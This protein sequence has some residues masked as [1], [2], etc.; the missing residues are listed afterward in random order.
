T[1]TLAQLGITAAEADSQDI[2]LL[3]GGRVRLGNESPVDNAQVQLTFRDAG[4][5]AIATATANA[6][7]D[8]S[9]WELIGQRSAI[10][11]GT[12]SV[13]YVFRTNRVTGGNADGYFDQAFLYKLSENAAPD[14]GAYGD[15]VKDLPVAN[16]AA[17]IELRSPDFYLD[18][19]K[20]KP[21]NI[22]WETFGN[23]DDSPV[24]IDVYRD[25]AD[26]PKWVATVV[27]ATPDSGQYTWI[28]G[29]SGIDF[30]TQGLRIQVSLVNNA[31]V[32]DRSQ[33]PFTVPE[34]GATYYVNDGSTA[35]DEYTTAVGNNR[36]TG[37]TPDAPK[38]YIANLFRAYDLQAGATLYVDTGNYPQF[39]SLT[40][41]GTASRGYGID[42]GFVMTGPT[43]EGHVAS[44][45]PIVP[46]ERTWALLDMSDTD[47]VSIS[48]LQLRDAQRGLLTYGGTEAL[49]LDDIEAYGMVY[50]G[51]NA[52]TT[53][54]LATWTGLYMHDN[55]GTGLVGY[56]TLGGI[57]Q[58]VSSN[59]RTDG[60]Y[61]ESGSLGFITGSTF[62]ANSRFG[63]YLYYSGAT[64][65]QSSTF[66]GNG[67]TGLNMPVS[68]STQALVGSTDLSL[69]LGNR[70]IGNANGGA[71]F[72]GN[73][74]V[75][76]NVAS[77]NT[78][79]GSYGISISSG[80]ARLNVIFGNVNGLYAYNSTSAENRV[81]NNAG[82]GIYA[83]Y[84]T[85]TGN[86]IY[87]NDVG[88]YAYGNAV[89]R[90]NLIYANRSVGAQ[91]QGSSPQFI[92]NTV[93][94]TAG[95]AIQL[96]GSASS[97]RFI[98]N[99]IWV[100]AGG[101][102]GLNVASDSQV[103]FVSD[104]NIFQGAV[105]IW[106]GTQRG[107]LTAWQQASFGDANSQFTDPLFVNLLG[108]DGTLGTTDDDFHLKSTHGSFHGASLAPVIGANGLPML[109]NGTL[110]N[111]AQDSPGIDRG[112]LDQPF[113]QEPAPRG[114]YV[115]IG[116][117][118]NTR[119]AS[120]SPAVYVR[121]M[122]PNGGET[123]AEGETTTVTWRSDGFTGKV[124]IDISLDGTNWLSVAANVDNTGSYAWTPTAGQFAGGNYLL[125]VSSVAQPAVF[126]VSDAKFRLAAT[127]SIFYVNDGSLVGDEYATAI[128]DDAN[129][130]RSADKPKAS[131]QALLNAYDFKPGDIILIDAGVYNLS[132]NLLV[133]AQDSGVL[134][135]GALTHASVLNRGNTN[136]GQ[137]ALQLGSNA[138]DVTLD[139]LVLSGGQYG[140]VVGDNS[141]AHRF[142]I[143]NSEVTGNSAGG[144]YVGQNVQD[145]TITGNLVHD[146]GGNGIYGQ[147][148]LRLEISGNQVYNQGT[149]ISTYSIGSNPVAG[150]EPMITGNRVHDVSVGI[151]AQYNG[152]ILNNTVWGASDRGIGAYSITLATGNT[153]WGSSTGIDGSSTTLRNNIVYANSTGLTTYNLL[154][155]GNR[156][157][158]NT[159]G[160]SINGYTLFRNNI[161]YDN[162]N[163]VVMQSGYNADETHGFINNTIVQTG[164]TAI[165][166]QNAS[167]AHL[168][169]NIID[170]RGGATGVIV[171][172]NSEGGFQSDYNL[173]G[174][175]AGTVLF[176]WEGRDFT[177]RPDWVYETGFDVNSRIA[178]ASFV[179]ANGADDLSG[180][181]SQAIGAAKILDDGDA[182][183]V[184]TGSWTTVT[185]GTGGYQGDRREASG[186]VTGTGA[187]YA[188]YTFTGLTAGTYVIAASWNETNGSAGNTLFSVYDGSAT[189]D[190]LTRNFRVQQYS[191]PNDYT[192]NGAKWRDLVTVVVTGDTLTLRI[193]DAGSYGKIIADAVKIQRIVG[194]AGAD[195][196]FHLQPGSAGVDGGDPAQSYV[197][198]PVNNGA[199]VDQGAY[200]NTPG[201]TQS[202]APMVQVIGPA[203]FAKLEVGTPATISWHTAGLIP[204]EPTLL[205]NAGNGGPVAGGAQGNWLRNG[206]MT[207]SYGNSS[208]T[209][210]VDVSGVTNPAPQA[211]YQSFSY[212][213]GTVGQGLSWQLPVDDGTYTVRLHFA[214]DYIYTQPGY[215]QFDIKLNGTVVQSNFDIRATTGASHKAVVK[216]Y[217]VTASGGQGIDLDLITKTSGWGAEISGI[218]ILRQVPAG[219]AAATVDLQTSLDNGL[220]WTTLASGLA[221]DRF[222]NGSY[223]WTPEQAT[224]ANTA[225]IRVIAHAGDGHVVASD[226]SDEP[227][228]IA[229]GG[230]AYYVNDG[231][232]AGD[233]YTTAIGDNANS[234]KDA[235][236]PMASLTALL[237]AY[238]LNPGDTVYVDTGHYTLITNVVIGA[239][240]SGV[241]VVGATVGAS[242]L[243]RNNTNGGQYPLQ[244]SGATGVTIQNLKLTGGQYGLV[245]GD[246]SGSHGFQLIG[247]EVYG[248]TSGGIYIGQNVAD[249]RVTGNLVHDNGGTGIYNQYTLRLVISGNEVYNQGAGIST[250][251]IGSSAV[252]GDETM[253]RGN[254]VHDV[255]VG[256]QVQYNGSA[257]D[258]LIWA[259]SDRGLA[260]YS[261]SGTFTGN[262]IWGSN[263]G[264]DVSSATLGANTV[265]GST[266]GVSV[267]NATAFGLRLYDN[268]LGASVTGYSMFRNNLLWDNT[269]AIRVSGTYSGDDTQGIVNNTIRQT[270]GRA[271]DVQANAANVRI[272]DNIFAT[273]DAQNIVVP[274]NSQNGYY[275]DYNLFAGNQ[276]SATAPIF[277]NWQGHDF[278]TL[279][280][281]RFET[282]NDV[283]SQIG[284]ANFAD[285]DGADDLSGWS[286]APIGAARI[287]DD[288]DIGVAFTGSWTTV[289]TG[290][291]GFQNDRR[292]ASG[293][294]TGS[295][296][297]YATYTFTGL[298][299]GTYVIAASWND[300]NGA[301]SNTL[302]SVYDGLATTGNLTRNFR[303]GQNTL[304]SDYTANGAKWRDL[305]TVVVTGDT[306]TVRISD[307]GSYGKIIADA[308]KI[309]Q[310][311]GDAGADDDFH[312]AAGSPGVDGGDPTLT[313]VMEPV[314]NGA[315]I[316][317][318]AYGNTPEA[319][320]SPA[321]LIQ[322]NG[323][324]SYA[325][326][327]V[328]TPTT[329]SWHTA[330]LIGTEPALLINAGNTG[331][332]AG[333]TLGNWVRNA[334]QTQGYSY[335]S[336]TDPVD[337]SGVTN[338]APQS[339][340]QS[341]VYANGTVGQG[342][343]W[344]LPVDD[345]Q[346]VV[347]LH[348][349]D[350]Y[351]YTQPGYRKIDIVLN[352]TVVQ[353]NFDIRAEAGAYRKAVVKEFNVVAS[354]GNGIDL[355]LIT[356]NSGWGAEISGIEILRV[357]PGGDPQASV[358]LQ[359]SLDNGATWQTLAT[360]LKM[361][362][363]GNGSY[364][365][366]PDQATGGNTALIRA[367]AHAG[368]GTTVAS[369]TSDEPFLIANGGSVF[370]VNDGS[371]TGDE[372]TTAPGNNANSGKDAAHPM[373]S[374]TALLRAYDLNPGDIVYV[375]TGSY[376]QYTNLVLL[377][378]DSGV[379]IQGPTGL[380]HTATLDRAN[381]S[382]SG[383]YTVQFAGADN[384]TLKNLAITGGQYGV[385]FGTNADSDGNVLANDEIHAATQ[386]G[387]W[388]G[389]LNDNNTFSNNILRNN[390]NRGYYQEYGNNNLLDGNDIR[391]NRVG[392]EVDYTN[393]TS[394]TANTVSNNKIH[395]NSQYGGYFYA[396]SGVVVKGNEVYNQAGTGFYA[397]YS[398]PYFEANIVHHN[399]TGFDVSQG[400]WLK[401][402]SV[403][404]NT[405]GINAYQVLIEGNK[406]YSNSVGLAENG[407]SRVI[408]NVIYANS[409]IGVKVTGGHTVGDG[410]GFFN[411]TILQL[412]GEG[413]RLTGGASD[414]VFI[415]NI[416]DVQAGYGMSVDAGSATRFVSNNNLLYRGPAANAFI[417]IWQG[418]TQATLAGW[419]TAS[420]QDAKSVTGDPKFID[421]DGAD[422][423]LG[424]Q[425]LSTGNGSDDNFELSA[426]SPAIDAANAY[427]APPK[428]LEGRDRRDDPASTN[429]GQGW[430]L[431]VPADQGSSL[432]TSGGTAL[433]FRTSDY[434][435]QITLPFAFS[436]YGQTYTQLW[437]NVNGFIQFAGPDSPYTGNNNS[438]DV[439]L[440]NVRI[441]VLWDDLDTGPAGK[442]IFTSST[443]TSYTIRWQAKLQGTN[444]DVNASLTLF[445]NGQVRFDYG[446][447]NT[448]L[449]PTVG[450]SAGNGV[451]YVLSSY[452]GQ[453]S[454]ASAN[455]LLWTPTPGLVY[456]DIG[457]YEFQGNSGDT[458]GP[459]VTTITQ[460]P[461]NGGS[462]AAAFSSI[463]VNFDEALNGVSARSPANYELRGAGA[464][465]IFDTGDD[466]LIK[467]T[468]F[469]SFP[470]TSLTLNFNG[471]LADGKYRLT[472]SGTKAIFDTAGNPLDGDGNGTP[473]GDYIRTFTIDRSANHAPVANPMTVSVNENGSLT[474]TLAATDADGDVLT[475]TIPTDV[476]HGTL[477]ALDPNTHQLTYTPDAGFNGTDSFVFK[478]DD[479]KTGVSSATVSITVN[480]V[481]AAPVAVD[482]SASLNEGGSVSLLLSASDDETAR[483]N[484]TFELVTGPAHGTVT[485]GAGGAWVYTANAG[486]VGS[487]SFTWRAKDRGDPDGS[488]GNAKNS[489]TATFTLNVLHVNAAPVVTPVADQTVNEGSTIT[490]QLTATDADGPGKTWTLLSGPAGSTLDAATGLFTWT[491]AD[492]PSSF[493]VLVRV[494][495]GGSPNAYADLSFKILVQDV[496]P[497]LAFTTPNSG[498]GVAGQAYTFTY[499]VTDPGQDTISSLLVDWGDG[500]VETVN[501]N[502]KSLTHTYA[503]GQDGDYTVKVSPTDEDGAHAPST[504]TLHME[505]NDPPVANAQ[506]VTAS[507]G[508]P[509][510]IQLSG[511]DPEGSALVYSL[512]SGPA[513]GTLGAVDPATGIVRYTSADDYSG[514]DSFVFKVTDAG[515]KSANATVSI[516][517]VAVNHAPVITPVAR[518]SVDEGQVLTLTLHASDADGPNPVQWTLLNGPAGATL[519][520][521]TGVLSW[522]AKDG[523]ATVSFT[524]QADDGAGGKASL[525]FDADVQDVAPTLAVSG[526]ATAQTG[527][528]YAIT[529]SATDPGQDTISQWVIDW[530]DGQQSTLAGTAT[531]ASHSYAAAGSFAVQVSATNEDGSFAAT[532][533]N[534][535]VTKSNQAP[536]ATD[537][538]YA[539]HAGQVLDIAA[540]GLLSNDSDP[541]GDVLS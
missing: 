5:N 40:L 501:G 24:R 371:S 77:G 317:Q 132:T 230:T 441:A 518:Q 385:V 171:T 530:G 268:A 33:E 169:S 155:E 321:P 411:N 197:Q 358:D 213:N 356:K 435:T 156:S 350:D 247:N 288:G 413:V 479:G 234:G 393:T 218:E 145:G 4:G 363:F 265:Y 390:G 417:G 217:T 342:L 67:N 331:P 198:E 167:N 159:L 199:R 498:K 409:N 190:D 347:R 312:L 369:D 119:L 39:E 396:D 131:L 126:D 448:G 335:G 178:E 511:S 152:Q 203:G 120:L 182:G 228:L 244:L 478:V 7:G 485:Q 248:N 226:T 320:Q 419:Q 224:A 211:V 258:N 8:I 289:T 76:G 212:A 532:P 122:S 442:D 105:G 351:I 503:D 188:T 112:A 117:D 466:Q 242:I 12:R 37:K 524:V 164:G 338:P 177:S 99:I 142:T 84:G 406:I 522:L 388:I 471:I 301:A 181:A 475:Y 430:D 528:P 337:V 187:N 322:V 219:D 75:A 207:A 400:G 516:T 123:V 59:N 95:D 109:L 514:A 251:S 488:N 386:D 403:Y 259:A 180:Y 452:D 239:Q 422:N 416:V 201:A 352:G 300:T 349:A 541:D 80:E 500:N 407:Y 468:P 191:L 139:H 133:D 235:A 450:L 436:F 73:V 483:A 252:A 116:S 493:D 487:D 270:G 310:I 43:G 64:R 395:D 295:G 344:D 408:N 426:F 375:D 457:A 348:F 222:G 20:F 525:S 447:G 491:P 484:L 439:L 272:V 2:Q 60:L 220:T 38:P 204:T 158:D 378:E 175:A 328:G 526:A 28:P 469:Y 523:N 446:A 15:T 9:R 279:L 148:T 502:P 296:A 174:Q 147:Y 108:A 490:V 281:W 66:Q 51:I 21:L 505:F 423:I 82:Y 280:N 189:A 509:K 346:Y 311:V 166:V 150:D 88:F 118:G 102:V 113:D 160:A 29:N 536:V 54:P 459:K 507:E 456:Y 253:I 379:T 68:S 380:G 359:T 274:S 508:Q 383:A 474:I 534:V 254:Q 144:I 324:D 432:F 425:G 140:L 517:V 250:Y 332:V 283:H 323:P 137:Y 74:L 414:V 146:N 360:G 30:G 236:H 184:F 339:V 276:D 130:G 143:S 141:G 372:Y 512:V 61:W 343:S 41:S 173:F 451:S 205:L 52:N 10:P 277:I 364:T 397:V 6:S 454:L 330:G 519:D 309:Q 515:G 49:D 273:V 440:R 106:Q 264:I 31:A 449:T 275:S 458:T 316:D 194:D 327:E 58:L 284:N 421:I 57:D 78:G 85:V 168:A 389:Q 261:T 153:V 53:S 304:P 129:D 362:R 125:R 427:Q 497:T 65:I 453:S 70:F 340:Y 26:G 370:Y 55:G 260:V 287:L 334:Y 90:S 443:A 495:D 357:V 353:A 398:N 472:L 136:S 533:L 381:T 376:T 433:N 377:A 233:E 529:F 367:V 111:D 97:A 103:G 157:Y 89:V 368:D 539:V 382:Y 513:H 92:G 115:N 299:A 455:S 307:Q 404:A 266:L 365:W 482:Q 531:T 195:D 107:T 22:T 401:N 527:Q 506:S 464:D 465:G 540:P 420:G 91:F 114:G 410:D 333:G 183:V 206:Y 110:T 535:A 303:V 341:Y 434:A 135:R 134:I 325:K 48:H 424:E 176:N 208:Y 461:P 11:Y 223:Q 25:T 366:T 285:A 121:V 428:D 249:G 271:I 229:N 186:Y 86:T 42:E 87:G 154:A 278:D 149:G 431:F 499:T 227:F 255:N 306:L 361:D 336:Y 470:E 47:F 151:Q 104:Y 269:N 101:G 305:V 319:T 192:Q 291:S 313:Y 46:N 225:L 209:D 185:T 477:S 298:T 504:L 293:Y 245:V 405:T 445:S 392:V 496:A 473:G 373:A 62:S 267:Y 286:T 238:D 462:T 329:I 467:L 83:P 292:E 232:T 463:Q 384:V 326:L 246:S 308:V 402:N 314:N 98:D 486:Y 36:N 94:Q 162:T 243:D 170:L 44:L 237:R 71:S 50:E 394:S 72:S 163:G 32:L 489:N 345:G 202:P 256:I 290:T 480:P 492:G 165:R 263:T 23:T 210:A 510:D 240:D 69:N 93:Y 391:N 318:G 81:Y 18:W 437:I 315:R 538:S 200:G 418:A 216:E 214:D 124:N 196:D 444:T 481:N 412:V 215:R 429:K 128:G 355:D 282:G 172:N 387:I 35:G 476:Q 96:Y 14:I 262:T 19:E 241:K 34:D 63:A 17:R 520:A 354:G 297:N 399:G 100:A 257:E 415:N 374:L 56:G 521:D 221:M 127:T 161:L 16:N 494:S 294:V 45:F 79:N 138:T 13:E 193:S 537:D 1:F 3:F 460:L 438:T 302:F 231:S 179:D 27:G